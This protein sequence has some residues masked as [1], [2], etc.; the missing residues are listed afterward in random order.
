MVHQ[1]LSRLILLAHTTPSIDGTIYLGPAA[2]PALGRENYKGLKGQEPF[3]A[4]NFIHHMSVQF[5]TNKKI[6][7]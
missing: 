5:M 7:N 3:M 4:M 6:R 1:I 2:T